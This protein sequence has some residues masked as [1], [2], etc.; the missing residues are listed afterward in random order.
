M[1]EVSPAA[2]RKRLSRA[3]QALVA[4]VGGQ[5]GIV[6]PANPCRCH[7]LARVRREAGLLSVDT[8]QFDQPLGAEGAQALARTQQADLTV[9]AR[10]AALLRTHP[11]YIAHADL[12]ARVER[13]VTGGQAG[14]THPPTA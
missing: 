14:I 4:F 7:K 8:L 1:M 2:Y 13:I 9:D 3:R 11:T 10:T 6:N 5:C 12:A